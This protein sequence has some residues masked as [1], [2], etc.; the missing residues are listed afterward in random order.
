MLFEHRL[1][2][3]MSKASGINLTEDE[4]EDELENGSGPQDEA[5]DAPDLGENDGNA[6]EPQGEAPETT[7]PLPVDGGYTI[8]M[9]KNQLDGV[10][11]QFPKLSVQFPEGDKRHKFIEIEER[12]SEISAVLA[13]DFINGGN[14]E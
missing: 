7:E 14:N 11:K 12:L 9:A 2:M 8:Q 3:L 4:L 10:I 1:A 6:T 5:L 13:R